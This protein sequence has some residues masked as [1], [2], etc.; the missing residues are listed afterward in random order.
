MQW[1]IAALG[2][3]LGFGLQEIF[4]N[5]ISGLI[6][7]AER[8]IRIGDVVTVG[9]VSGTVARIRARA[10]A[11]VD[12]DNKEVIIPNKAFVTERVVNW[13]PEPTT[14][15]LLKVG[16]A[17]GSDVALV[18][19]VL[20]EACAT[21]ACCGTWGRRC[22]SS[23]SATARS[24]SRSAR[25]WARLDQRLRVRHE[26]PV[27]VARARHRDPVPAAGPPHPLGP[28]GR[29]NAPRARRGFRARLR[30]RSAMPARRASW[31]RRL[32]IAAAAAVALLAGV[33]ALFPL[34]VDGD[35]RAARDRA[36]DLGAPRR[37]RGP[38]RLAEAALL[39][40][41]LRRSAQRHRPHPALRWPS[42]G[43]SAILIA[44]LPLQAATSALS[45]SRSRSRCSRSRSRPG[46]AARA[47]IRL[48]RIARRSAPSWMPGAERGGD[49]ARDN[50][51]RAGRPPA[52]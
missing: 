1:L 48:P 21:P 36:A 15:L 46:A 33:V 49:V 23:T 5:F 40:P 22:S 16:V 2:V 52:R 10:T 27:E 30:Y 6:V 47:A 39:P 14:R 32:A 29:L 26:L 8:P 11:V 42:I 41:A 24:T 38:L 43:T 3:G 19:R 18:Q 31:L 34:F 44:A 7:L 28:G 13:T 51:R 12:F 35:Q 20:L 45:R 50:G 9:D 17:Y 25:S 4:A 37:G